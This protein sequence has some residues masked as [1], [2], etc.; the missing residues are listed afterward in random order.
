MKPLKG[1]E[2][3]KIESTEEG[4]TCWELAN[5]AYD[6]VESPGIL[7]LLQNLDWLRNIPYKIRAP[8]SYT[9]L[10]VLEFS[11]KNPR[12]PEDLRDHAR[13]MLASYYLEPA[14]DRSVWREAA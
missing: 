6:L 1:T 11:L 4:E 12:T 3:V 14:E 8:H 5:T 13:F 9:L 7:G 2:G 10:G